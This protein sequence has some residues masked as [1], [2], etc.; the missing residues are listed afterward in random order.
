V[1]VPERGVDASLSSDCVTSGGEE[2]GNARGIEA[3]L[4]E[5]E[6]STQTGT[7]GTDDNRI[8]FVILVSTRVNPLPT[9]EYQREFQ[10]RF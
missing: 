7:A 8:V 4:R 9:A 10:P 5:S 3:G 6:G 1:H 2:L